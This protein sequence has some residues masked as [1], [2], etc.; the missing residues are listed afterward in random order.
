MLAAIYPILDL[1]FQLL[2]GQYDKQQT[3]A[4]VPGADQIVLLSPSQRKRGG[5]FVPLDGAGAPHTEE[6]KLRLLKQ[7]R[8]AREAGRDPKADYTVISLPRYWRTR[9]HVFILVALTAASL[10]MAI[11]FFTPLVIGREAMRMVFSELPHDG[12]NLVSSRHLGRAK[13]IILDRGRIYLLVRLCLRNLCRQ[14]DSPIQQ[15]RPYSSIRSFHSVQADRPFATVEHVFGI[16]AVPRPAGHGGGGISAVHRY[17]WSIW[18]K[19][20]SCTGIASLGCL[21]CPLHDACPSSLTP[22]SGQW[23]R[24]S[25]RSLSG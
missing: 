9:I 2:F 17:A 12:Y 25:T 1:P 16:H 23:A 20:R 4:R 24:L 5:V 14:T 10:T 11:G 22:Q 18:F 7:D 8:A 13:L 19:E 15:G 21:V 3:D 6:D